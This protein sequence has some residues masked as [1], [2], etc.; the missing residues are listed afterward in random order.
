MKSKQPVNVPILL[1]SG[2]P[3]YKLVE[4][5]TYIWKAKGTTWQIII[6]KGYK[7]DGASAPRLAWTLS[8]LTPDGLI[9]AAALVHDFIYDHSGHL[10]CGS[11]KCCE[12]G[13]CTNVELGIGGRLSFWKRKEADQLFAN[14]MKEC[15]V[16]KFQRRVAYLAVRVGGWTGW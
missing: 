9:R 7:S 5:Y 12:N 10:P 8:G 15:G 13:I 16:S 14:I 3:G 4:K 2:E 1:N 11:F 6:P